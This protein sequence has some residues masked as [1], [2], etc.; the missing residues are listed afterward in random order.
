MQSLQSSRGKKLRDAQ[1]L[2]IAEGLQSVREALTSKLSYLEVETL[3]LTENAQQKYAAELNL[4]KIATDKLVLVSE[5]VMRSMTSAETPQ[6]IL[7]VCVNKQS[8]NFWDFIQSDANHLKNSKSSGKRIA[9]F[10]QIQDPGN[11]GAVIRSA[12]ACGFDAVVF[13]TESVDVYNPKTVRATAGSLWHIPVFSQ[14][15]IE[16]FI[17]DAMK[18][19]FKCFGLDAKSDDVLEAIVEKLDEKNSS[20]WLFGN[21]ARGLP[22]LSNGV[23]TVS[24]PMKGSAESF[25]LAAAA[26]IVMY[27]VTIQRG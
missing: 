6:G 15:P 10:W 24:I 9:Y 23:K 13:S 14:L 27:L 25:N 16:D 2:F 7:A 21:E 5:Q 3:Y 19:D 22:K 8:L 26:A 1:N 12:D 17:S 4:I 11:A 20:V 18:N